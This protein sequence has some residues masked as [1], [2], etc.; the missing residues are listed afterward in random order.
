M[1]V[2]PFISGNISTEQDFWSL[3]KAKLTLA[4]S[5]CYGLGFL[6]NGLGWRQCHRRRRHRRTKWN[7]ARSKQASHNN[8]KE[9]SKKQTKKII[10]LHVLLENYPTDDDGDSKEWIEQ[11]NEPA[12]ALPNHK[13]AK[14][15]LQSPSAP[16]MNISVG[17][18]ESCNT[19]FLSQITNQ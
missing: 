6:I 7:W 4:A 14:L 15:Q 12:L 16:R 3:L 18:A 10:I 13:T 9:S 8:R 5:A 11:T 19:T 2:E 17:I 1:F